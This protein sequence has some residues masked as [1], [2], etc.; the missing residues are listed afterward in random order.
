MSDEVVRRIPCVLLMARQ[1]GKFMFLG[2]ELF[3]L[4]RP[5]RLRM[6]SFFV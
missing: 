2:I 5:L 1:I 4:V 3:F 6:I